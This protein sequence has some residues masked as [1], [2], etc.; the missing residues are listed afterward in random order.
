MQNV[1]AAREPA[2]VASTA[3]DG[4]T[5]QITE[6]TIGAYTLRR[7]VEPN[8]TGWVVRSADRNLPR[9][10]DNSPDRTPE[11]GVS[12]YSNGVMNPAGAAAY[13]AQI[14]EAARAALT[15]NEIIASS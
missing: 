4:E 9:I 6:W 14:M 1:P 11:F 13:A 10:Q 3:F 7:F 15:F 8:Y 5:V 12:C 2:P